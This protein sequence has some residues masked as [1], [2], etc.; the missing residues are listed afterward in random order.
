MVRGVPIGNERGGGLPLD[1]DH[2]G[3]IAVHCGNG[4][5]TLRHEHRAPCGRGNRRRHGR[6]GRQR[7]DRQ[8]NSR[9]P[10]SPPREDVAPGTGGGSSPPLIP[11][12]L[13]PPMLKAA[14]SAVFEVDSHSS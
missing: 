2:G 8:R 4:G 11:Y 10:C 5:V 9:R 12:E 3:N 14:S 6:N 1:G 13:V 7:N